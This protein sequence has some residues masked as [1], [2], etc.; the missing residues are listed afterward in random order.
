MRS[1]PPFGGLGGPPA[2]RG[3]VHIVGG[4]PGE[5]G[6]LTLRAATLLASC[7]VVA[8][9]HLSP[10]EALDLV[11]DHADRILVGRRSGSPG[12]EREELD[13]LLLARAAA[14]DAV[15]RLKGGDPFVF[16]RGGEEAAACVEAGQ[17]FEVV[18]GVSSAVAVPGAAGIPVTHRLVARGFAVVTG[19]E[20]AGESRAGNDPAALAAFPGTLVLL[21]GLARLR[22]LA[23]SLIANGRSPQTPAAV[24]SAGT[25]PHQ[26]SVRATLA[27]IAD[28][29]EAGDVPTPA[30]IVVGEVVALAETLTQREQRPLHGLR[31]LLPR[32]S[33]GPSSLAVHLRHA[34][35]DV[36]QFELAEERP[37]DP[38][39]ISRLAVDVREHR[40]DT[41]VVLDVRGIERLLQAL[42]SLGGDVRSLARVRLVAVGRTTA[43]H[44]SEEHGLGPDRSFGDLTELR[45]SPDA[46]AGRTVVLAPLGDGEG[47]AE[48][49]GARAVASSRLSPLDVAALP[50][51]DV[52]VVPASRL[53][54]RLL[55]LAGSDTLP[56]VSLGP[57]ASAALRE[58]GRVPDAETE[59]PTPAALVAALRAF[60]PDG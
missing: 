2:E 12:Y 5:P 3:T 30:V 29:A 25:R 21:M 14:G 28:A 13:A 1:S 36:I 42:S 32:L 8:Y 10:P 31:V 16:G 39:T 33:G 44:L 43:R 4:G 37:P 48:A 38:A 60:A 15:V 9:D 22:D 59:E 45:D 6:Y 41:L 56:L 54:A 7:D 55:A 18:P 24:V 53:V 20:A 34:G 19:H 58:H 26:R 52:V 57:T 27:T 35:A 51:G 50:G 23:E 47:L 46:L 40:V 17:P 11:P 49:L